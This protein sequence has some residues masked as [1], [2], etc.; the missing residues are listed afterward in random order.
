MVFTSLVTLEIYNLLDLCEN[1]DVEFYNKIFHYYNSELK[2]L[3]RVCKSH[4]NYMTRII[5]TPDLLVIFQVRS[6]F[7]ISVDSKG[8]RPMCSVIRP[9]I[10]ILI[11]PS[12][13]R[14]W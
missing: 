6:T 14:I 12:I 10:T 2:V 9:I 1:M 11:L 7:Y 3:P 8:I 13:S 4:I 5:K